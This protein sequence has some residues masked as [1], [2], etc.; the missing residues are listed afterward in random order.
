MPKTRHHPKRIVTEIVVKYYDASDTTKEL[1][2]FRVFH[3]GDGEAIDTISWNDELIDK[4]R[5]KRDFLFHKNPSKKP[6]TGRWKTDLKEKPDSSLKPLNNHCLWL[7]DEECNWWS[8]C[9]QD[10]RADAP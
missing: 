3:E 10:S 9:G 5:Y 8:Y 6:G 7:H 1:Q 2:Q 4:I